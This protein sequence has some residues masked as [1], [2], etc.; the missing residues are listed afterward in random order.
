[1]SDAYELKRTDVIKAICT[2]FYRFWHNAPGTNT[3]QGF[4]DWWALNVQR[5]SAIANQ[6]AAATIESLQAQLAQAREQ[7]DYHRTLIESQGDE[8]VRQAAELQQAREQ[9]AASLP[10]D[11]RKYVPRLSEW[12]KSAKWWCFDYAGSSYF[13]SHGP[14]RNDYK[15]EKDYGISASVIIPAEYWAQWTESRISREVAEVM[16]IKAENQQLRE[17]LAARNGFKASTE[18]EGDAYAFGFM[19]G[20]DEAN[21]ATAED[22]KYVY[23]IG[24]RLFVTG[25]KAAIQALIM[26]LG[27]TIKP[28]KA[29][30]EL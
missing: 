1:M 23:G 30:S 12:P 9:V 7:S 25:S 2:D 29:E 27:R 6:E 13:Y 3:D 10:D 8:I 5:Y 14:D 22:G 28:P 19:D 26:K 11:F 18:A 20:I 24:S 17:R 15:W 21:K 16:H 4:D